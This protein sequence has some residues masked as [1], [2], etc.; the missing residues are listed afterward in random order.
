MPPAALCNTCVSAILTN[1]NITLTPRKHLPFFLNAGWFPSLVFLVQ[2]IL[3]LGFKAYDR[4][5]L[6]DIPMHVLGG[7]A[8]A[9]F[10]YLSIAY[11][12]QLGLVRVGSQTARL[13]MVFGLVAASTV[14]WEVAEFLADYF[15]HVGAQRGLG[16][17]MKDQCM[18]LIGGIAY[19]ARI[20]RGALNQIRLT[21]QRPGEK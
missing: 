1:T 12:D 2:C 16:D 21:E 17:T 20:W 14:I 5:P 13:I 19:S 15:F 4:L 7:I 10:F 18:G 8:I 3:S 9:H 11:L 6:L